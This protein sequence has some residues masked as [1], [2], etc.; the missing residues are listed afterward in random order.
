[1]CVCNEYMGM[2]KI[3]NYNDYNKMILIIIK[4]EFIKLIISLIF[5]SLEQLFKLFFSKELLLYCRLFD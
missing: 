3:N 5:F 2:N 1:M 4:V